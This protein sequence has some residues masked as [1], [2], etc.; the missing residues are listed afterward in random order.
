MPHLRLRKIMTWPRRTFLL[1]SLC[2]VISNRFYGFEYFKFIFKFTSLWDSK[3]YNLQLRADNSYFCD[4]V[5]TPFVCLFVFPSSHCEGDMW[6]N[7]SP[8]RRWKRLLL[9]SVYL[10]EAAP[11]GGRLSLWGGSPKENESARLLTCPAS[12]VKIFPVVSLWCSN[13]SV[14]NLIL[15]SSCSFAQLCP[16][17]CEP[18]DCS[19]PGFSVLHHL[20]ELAPTHVRLFSQVWPKLLCLFNDFPT[21]I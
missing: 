16:T 9:T 20:L 6:I 11:E 1:I 18:M 13:K 7:M 10:T 19:T 5:R 3:V 21:L 15:L 2:V 17:L 12:L 4:S 14:R 8:S